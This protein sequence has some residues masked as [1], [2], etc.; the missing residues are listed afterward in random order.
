M[1]KER[2]RRPNTKQKIF[3]EGCVD[4]WEKDDG[5]RNQMFI[6]G[7][8][9]EE[10]QSWDARVR[11]ALGQHAEY[12][13]PRQ[14]REQIHSESLKIKQSANVALPVK[15]QSKNKGWQEAASCRKNNKH[16]HLLRRLNEM[17]WWK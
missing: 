6:N 7:Q 1:H 4:R 16:T 17:A 11:E 9:K 12:H 14:S 5:Y 2:S 3:F 13:R 10:L 8:A 15:Q